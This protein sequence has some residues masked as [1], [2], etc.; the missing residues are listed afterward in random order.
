MKIKHTHSFF[1]FSFPVNLSN[2]CLT[3]TTFIFPRKFSFYY[4]IKSWNRSLDLSTFLTKELWAVNNTLEWENTRYDRKII[5]F[6]NPNVRKIILQT[7][8]CVHAT[9]HAKT[10]H[11]RTKIFQ[12]LIYIVNQINCFALS[13]S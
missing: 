1:F 8:N 12:V 4:L 3:K 2:S 10:F 7:L 6:L 9:L 5:L 11:Q 13:L